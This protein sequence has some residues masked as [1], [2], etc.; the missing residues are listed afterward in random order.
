MKLLRTIRLDTSDMFIFDKPAAP[1]EWAVSGAFMFWGSDP[2]ALEG[3]ARSAFRG[4]FLGVES[5]GWST[6]VQIVAAD[7]AD[8]EALVQALAQQ[9]MAEFGAPDIDAARGAAEEE[10]AFAESLCN[11]PQDTLVAVHRSYDDGAVRES[12]RTLKPREGAAP[13]RA[14]SFMDVEGED[15][16]GEQ[17]DLISMAERDRK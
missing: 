13:A 5:F 6:L 4:G 17:V 15:E 12:F 8:R 14:F 3:K 11:Q 16:A 7:E 9:L 10:V 2:A 1:G